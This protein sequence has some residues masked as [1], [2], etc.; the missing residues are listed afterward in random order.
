MVCVNAW[1][2][3]ERD[4]GNDLSVAQRCQRI[5]SKELVMQRSR[6]GKSGQVD[7][8]PSQRAFGRIRFYSVGG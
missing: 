7:R 8:K 1:R 4:I 3:K 6:G 5:K 2:W